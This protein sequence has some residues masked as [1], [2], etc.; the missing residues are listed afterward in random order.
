[1]AL[2]YV[3]LYNNISNTFDWVRFIRCLLL[4][5]FEYRYASMD[6]F[7]VLIAKSSIY[8]YIY[9]IDQQYVHCYESGQTIIYSWLGDSSTIFMDNGQ[10]NEC[11]K[12]L[13]LYASIAALTFDINQWLTIDWLQKNRA[14]S[15]Q[16]DQQVRH[17]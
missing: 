17:C 4:E 12:T 1:M 9:L 11:Y 5:C 13:L 7:F 3:C 15:S 10:H 16:P 8:T 14:K 6:N 2:K